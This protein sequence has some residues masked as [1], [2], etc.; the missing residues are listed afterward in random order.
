MFLCDA[1]N[2][3]KKLKSTIKS[4]SQNDKFVSNLGF[5]TK[6]DRMVNFL[7]YHGANLNKPN[8]LGG[9]AIN[10]HGKIFTKLVRYKSYDPS[11][12]LEAQLKDFE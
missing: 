9:I 1:E 2:K 4:L 12:N 7:K 6:N 3:A 10:N 8:L 5:L 11:K